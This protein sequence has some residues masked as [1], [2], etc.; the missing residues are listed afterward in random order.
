MSNVKDKVKTLF[1]RLG[2]TLKIRTV[3]DHGQF[4]TNSGTYVNLITKDYTFKSIVGKHL[5][6]LFQGGLILSNDYVIYVLDEGVYTPKPT[7]KVILTGTTKEVNI[8]NVKEY[9]LKDEIIAFALVLE[10]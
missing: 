4:N 6:S 9:K 5:Y 3:I 8:K 7:D 1:D 2:S 10:S